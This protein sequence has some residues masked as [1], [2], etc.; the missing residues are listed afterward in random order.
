[1][2][3]G[4]S[5]GMSMPPM[6]R[7]TQPLTENQQSL[8]SE[9]LSQ[10][11]VDNISQEDAASIVQTFSEAGIEPGKALEQAMADSG[12]D[13]KVIGELANVEE[14]GHRPPPPPQKS[15]DEITSIID[16]LSKLTEEKLAASNDNSLSDADK[17]SILVQMMEEFNIE[18]GQSIINTSA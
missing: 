1:M 6:Q 10:F 5:S 12:F 18:D 2:I 9:T 8:I 3:N 13:A 14:D 11:D 7:S 16:Y 4:I 15:I 17:Q